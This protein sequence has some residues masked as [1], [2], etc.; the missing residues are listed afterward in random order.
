METQLNRNVTNIQI[1]VLEALIS[2]IRP[3]PFGV[4]NSRSLGQ[5]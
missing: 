3:A 2:M 5:P 1:R 4:F